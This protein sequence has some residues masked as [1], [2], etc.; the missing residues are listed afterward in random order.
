M[1]EAAGTFVPPDLRLGPTGILNGLSE[2]D[3]IARFRVEGRAGLGSPMPWEAFAR[4][5]D[6]DLGAIY[7]YL[8][9]LPPAETTPPVARVRAVDDRTARSHG[10]QL[11][12]R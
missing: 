9:T 4:M 3:F 12:T 8:K 11:G 10:M 2:Q 1:T 5:T 7:R 6:D